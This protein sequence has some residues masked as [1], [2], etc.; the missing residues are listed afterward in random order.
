VPHQRADPRAPAH[1]DGRPR[2]GFRQ[3]IQA[4]RAVAV[5]GV[6]LYHLWPR[7]VRGG[8]VGVD[9]FFVISG[10]LITRQLTAELSRS[11]R[12]SLS[13]FW[14]RRIRRLL[15]AAF[16][17]LAAS[18]AILFGLMPRVTWQNN[19]FEIR[20]AAAY[21]ENW[22]L[23]VHAVD[24]LAA[25]NS[26]TLVQHYWSLSVEEQFYL[27]WPLLLLLAAFVGR[28]AG[29]HR[30]TVL[31][32][33]L[34]A[35]GVVS[36]VASLRLTA[37]QPPFAFFGTPARGWQF[38]A[39]GLAALLTDGRA[40][41]ATPTAARVR[42]AAAWC[43]LA[44][45]GYALFEITAADP[46]PGVVALLP[47]AGAVL[48]L[49]ADAPGSGWSP[50]RL[51]G[52]A[53]VQWI[54]DI[55]YSLYL[56]HWP[57]IIAAPWVLHAEPRWPAKLVILAG[58]V[59][60]AA[61]TKRFVEDP[62][63]TGARWRAHRWPAYGFA[64]STMLALVLVSSLSY[65]HVQH[66]NTV[67]LEQARAATRAAARAEEAPQ[68]QP[69]LPSSGSGQ[70]RHRSHSAALPVRLPRS[71]F[72]AA[73]MLPQNRCAHPFARPA[74]LDT[75]FA[76]NDGRGYQCLQDR[77]VPTPQ[78]C[79][80]GDT[81]SPTRT[82]AIVGNSH[83]RRLAPALD[84]YGKQHGWKIVLAAEIDCMGLIS[85]PVGSLQA[86]DGCLSWSGRVQQR[87]LAMPQLDAVIFAS[88]VD[89]RLYLVGANP[90]PR[91]LDVARGR[92]LATWARFQ[93]RGVRVIVTQDVPGMRPQQDPECIAMSSAHYDPCAVSRS[94]VVRSNFMTELAQQNPDLATY[95]PLDQYFCDATKC[96]GLIGGVVV[97]FDDHHLTATYSRSLAVYFG[98]QLDAVLSG[99]PGGS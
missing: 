90:S 48:V 69:A 73:A 92:V 1:R 87:L 60:L 14:A 31:V 19:V 84:V 59:V 8:F 54:G 74:T 70:R 9:V 77:G 20:A 52:I 64:L 58:S 65:V 6:V 18:L 16:L 35:A 29:R 51:A 37:H 76:A 43:G 40:A 28:R 72:G 4:L 56:W 38:A 13:R 99:S 36:F 53:P 33:L 11:G 49:A 41:A 46:F 3:D 85:T 80:F 32:A 95:V 34:G 10:F 39:G 63:R 83:A 91:D 57:L 86:G 98:A 50:L 75:A 67:A 12:I 2:A 61:L 62:V 22:L 97:Y 27:A 66:L 79:T 96:H 17:V 78:F 30:R 24:Y 5:A 81:T 68:P 26:P 89:A 71:C 93:R 7:A 55:S 23:A 25:E 15:P 82:V 21:F 47:V 45:I 42:R 94:S 88:H 44:L